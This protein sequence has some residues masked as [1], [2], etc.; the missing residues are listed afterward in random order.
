MEL[1]L[2]EKVKHL[3][4]LGEKVQVRPGYGRNF[5]IPQ[6]KAAPATKENLARFEARR[7]E[8]ERAQEEYL[9]KAQRRAEQI[10]EATLV[11]ERKTAPGGEGKL[12]GSVSPTDIAEAANAMGLELAKRE[13]LLPEGPIRQV[14]EY[15]IKVRLHADVDATLKVDIIAEA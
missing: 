14:G 9:A 13:I 5:L 11:I 8:L 1:V 3:G 4:G 6:G 12:F 2:L 15:K 7:A 10:E